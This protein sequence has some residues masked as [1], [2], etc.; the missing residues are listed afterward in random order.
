MTDLLRIG[1]VPYG[2]GD[3][4]LVGLE[5]EPGITFVREKPRML[6]DSLREGRLDAALVSSIE[7]FRRPGYRVAPDLGI[8]CDGPVRSVRA[9]HSPDTGPIRRVGLDDGSEASVALLKIFLAEGAFGATAAE[10]EFERVVPTDRPDDLDHDLVLL[11]GDKGLAADPGRRTA[12]DLGQLWKERTGLPF[13]FALW[14]MP[15]GGAASERVV[16]VLRAAA[17]RGA[18]SGKAL[19]SRDGTHHRRSGDEARGLEEFRRRAAALGLC[20]EDVR[21]EFLS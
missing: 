10:I 9:F 18:L 15:P 1:G 19:A 13:V 12:V 16:P 8:C 6:V 20:E 21:P 7:A 3:P 17:A 2:V 14:L 11:I 4:L 5:N